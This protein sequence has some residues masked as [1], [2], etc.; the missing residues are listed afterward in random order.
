M[1]P[2]TTDHPLPGRA[3][4]DDGVM[5]L[6][7]GWLPDR[8]WFPD[9]GTA[10]SVERVAVV[11]LVDPEAEG[12][13]GL[14]LLRLPSGAL[15][16]V[17]LVVRPDGDALPEALRPAVVG[18]TSSGRVVVDGCHDPAFVRAWL[19]AAAR[20]GGPS[21]RPEPPDLTGMRILSGEQ[22]NTSVVLPS[23]HPPAILTVFRGVSTGANPDVEVPAL[24]DLNIWGVAT[25]CLH[26]V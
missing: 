16:Q 7:A 21:P 3:P 12:E 24:S 9:K 25:R 20:P 15:L 8:R 6:L 5:P 13:V 10:G 17:P 22:S 23:L 4:A 14:H 18:T 11:D 2:S 26:H 1:T 19:A